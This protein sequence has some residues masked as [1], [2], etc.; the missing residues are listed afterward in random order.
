MDQFVKC[1]D[2][3]FKLNDFN[4][5][6][7]MYWNTTSNA[8]TCPYSYVIGSNPNKFSAPEE[9]LSV[10]RNEKIDVWSFGNVLYNI[11]TDE[12]PFDDVESDET[13]AL[14]RKKKIATFDKE[15][16]RSEDPV[17]KA[18]IEAV[19]MCYIQDWRQR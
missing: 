10:D 11:L 7:F 15:L 17:D 8:E 1:E 13:I 4:K 14:V 18:L 5:G 19:R 9:Y 3:R 12:D 2:G 16:L 6:H